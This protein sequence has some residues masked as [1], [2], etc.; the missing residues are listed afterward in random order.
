M[1]NE[2]IASLR[3]TS[4]KEGKVYDGVRN[5]VGFDATVIMSLVS[6]WAE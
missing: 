3:N 2:F 1:V 4:D 6:G 5:D